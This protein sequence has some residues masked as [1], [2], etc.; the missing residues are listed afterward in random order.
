MK[1]SR[2]RLEGRVGYWEQLGYSHEWRYVDAATKE[3]LGGVKEDWSGKEWGAHKRGRPCSTN[4]GGYATKDAAI[5]AVERAC[6]ALAKPR[7]PKRA[8]GRKG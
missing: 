7:S 1:Q 3:V 6:A 2:K 5:I 4:L 8:R